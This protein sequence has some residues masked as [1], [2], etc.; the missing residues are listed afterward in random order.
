MHFVSGFRTVADNPSDVTADPHVFAL[1]KPMS[2]FDVDAERCGQIVGWG[3]SD[4]A[5][6]VS[7]RDRNGLY[8]EFYVKWS[9]LFQRF[10]LVTKY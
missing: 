10:E 7:A 8:R 3:K 1:Y 6:V 4:N 2:F 5:Y 9:V